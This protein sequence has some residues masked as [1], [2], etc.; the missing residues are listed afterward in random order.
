MKEKKRWISIM[1]T[2]FVP[3]HKCL[4]DCLRLIYLTAEARQDWQALPLYLWPRRAR[5]GGSRPCKR[6]RS[7]AWRHTFGRSTFDFRGTCRRRAFCWLV[8]CWCCFWKE[9]LLL[10]V[11]FEK[12]LRQGELLWIFILQKEN[13]NCW[14]PFHFVI[15]NS[16]FKKKKFNDF[17][18]IRIHKKKGKV[19]LFF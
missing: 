12:V 15:E 13:G 10:L 9:R 1:M 4:G 6:K 3:W 5:R 19:I 18:Q 16:D 2:F 7:N 17:H 8:G 11:F 14:V